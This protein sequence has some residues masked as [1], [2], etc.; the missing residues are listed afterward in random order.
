MSNFASPV[1][2][3]SDTTPQMRIITDVITLIDPSD[4]PLVQA[5]GGLDGAA[6]KFSFLNWPGTNPEWLEDTLTPLT[7]TLAHSAT[8]TSTATAITVADGDD[9]QVGH[10]ILVDAEQMWISAVSTNDL[11]VVRNYGG[12]QA[13]H[14][15]L[16]A[17]TVVGM[18]RLEG[19]DSTAIGYTD[20]TTNSNYTQ[21]FHKEIK[22]TRSQAQIRQY[23]IADEFDYQ[24]NKAVPEL[25]RLVERQLHYGQRKA[26]GATTPRAFGGY[27]TFMTTNLVSGATLTQAA[28]ENAV[29]SAY[30]A[31]GTGPWIAACAPGNVQKIKNFYDSSLF[32]QV[33]T[34]E[35][36]VGVVIDSVRTPY[37]DVNLLLDRWALSTLIPLIDPKHAGLMTFSPFTQTP[38]AKVGDSEKGQVVGE[39]TFCLRQEK[40]H[41]QLTN[42]S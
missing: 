41:A 28:I 29:M 19:A 13:S 25:M 33:M 21:I 23:G 32:L 24:S 3:Y 20:R 38:L 10:I 26:G 6:G 12:T 40:A 8:I 1:S 31:G 35:T 14:A 42:V 39:F 37:G 2:T 15:S 34:D 30:I 27:T 4:A 17:Y 5:L 22:V 7:G 11:T 16:A 36:T 18:A 9:L